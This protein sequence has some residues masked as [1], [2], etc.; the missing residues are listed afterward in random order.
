MSLKLKSKHKRAWL[1]ALRSGDYQQSRG[2][3]MED[4]GECCGLGV[5]IDVLTDDW[6][7]RVPGQ[8]PHWCPQSMLNRA[9]PTH[10]QLLDDDPLTAVVSEWFKKPRGGDEI[11]FL[12]SVDS[13]TAKIISL[14]DTSG[15]SLAEIA[16]YIE[17]NH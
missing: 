3:L 7:V 1:K 13:F 15:M 2:L 14:N 17:G 11:D 5:A 12:D 8:F 9:C 4:N 6:W 16:D 10:Y